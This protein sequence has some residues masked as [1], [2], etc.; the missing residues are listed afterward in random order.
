ME[1][2]VT[3]K[4]R[5]KITNQMIH[6][7][8]EIGRDLF[9]HK[10]TRDDVDSKLIKVGI[11]NAS[12]W[13]YVNN[14]RYLISGQVFART[15][16]LYATEYFLS[17]IGADHGQAGLAKALKALDLH[18]QYYEGLNPM[19]IRCVGKRQVHSKYLARLDK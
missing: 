9:E 11:G 16:N 6:S 5:N 12:G 4:T 15:M 18:I 1:M 10:I 19:K 2:E 3:R 14:Y 8:Y 13:D 17:K 7:C